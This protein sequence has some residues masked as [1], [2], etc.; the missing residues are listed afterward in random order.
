MDKIKGNSKKIMSVA[1]QRVLSTI[2]GVA[3]II[4][5]FLVLAILVVVINKLYVLFFFEI[6]KMEFSH[7]IESILSIFILVK[8]FNI[9]FYYFKHGVIIIGRVIEIGI[10]AIIQ[11]TIFKLFIIEPHKMY[12]IA[13]LLLV[14]G[15]LFFIDRKYNIIRSND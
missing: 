15:I 10:I 13:A 4:T 11:E 1:S 3:K 14:L 2:E 7:I 5:L 12:A 9:I 6:F 8:S